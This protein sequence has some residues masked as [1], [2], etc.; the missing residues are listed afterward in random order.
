MKWRKLE[1]S[2]NVTDRR[3]VGGRAAAG[4]GGLGIIGVLIALFLGGG[5]DGGLGDLLGGLQPPQTPAG[6]QTQPEEFQGLDDQELFVSSVL[7]ST[8]TLWEEVFAGAQRDYQPAQLVLFTDATTSACGGATEQVGPHYC[9]VDQTIYIDLDFFALLEQRFG[10]STGEFAQ[11]YVIAHEVA[12]HVQNEL[13]IMGEMRTLQQQ[14][15]G[16]ANRLSVSL[17]LQ[18]DCLAGVWANSIFTRGDV[19][20]TGDIEDALSAASA[21]GD[22]NIQRE[23]QGRVHPESWTHGSSQQ[24]VEWFNTGYE[25]GDPNECNTF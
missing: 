2:D 17:E 13:G 6:E 11:A 19:L 5:G 9:P 24:R 12:H 7:G 15:P 4:V 20:E 14:D 10:A 22:D 1:R 25:T 18:A 16:S 3:G 8:E 23:T 21:V